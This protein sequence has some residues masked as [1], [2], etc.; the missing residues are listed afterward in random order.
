MTFKIVSTSPT[1]GFY[2]Q[3]PVDYLK[4][5]NCELEMILLLRVMP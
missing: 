2:V 1:F 5:H 3:E 4:A